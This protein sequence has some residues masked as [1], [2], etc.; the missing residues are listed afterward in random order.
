MTMFELFQKGDTYDD[1][2]V[3]YKI[4]RA[5]RGNLRQEYLLEEAVF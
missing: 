4:Q 2:N 1:N 3:I 5:N